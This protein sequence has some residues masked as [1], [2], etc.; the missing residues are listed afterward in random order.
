MS[1]YSASPL[2]HPRR[3]TKSKSSHFKGLGFG[4]ELQKSLGHASVDVV[5]QKF[6][7]G[8]L[9]GRAS[10][11]YPPDLQ[12][13]TFLRQFEGRLAGCIGHCLENNMALS[14]L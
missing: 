1:Q 7:W 2:P 11:P 13:V 14:F 12:I 6:Y 5:G 3:G 9:Y 4:N 8:K 10:D